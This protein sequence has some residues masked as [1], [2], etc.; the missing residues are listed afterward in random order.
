MGFDPDEFVAA[1]LA[2]RAEPDPVGALA[3]VI[4]AAISDGSSIDQALGTS[5]TP[6]QPDTLLASP[7]LT[8]Q[9]IVFR[10]GAR[11]G[12]HDH[13]M[14]AVVG[15]YAGSEINQLFERG[16]NG[17]VARG[18]SQVERGG[19]SILDTDVIHEVQNPRRE[20]TAGLHVYGGDIAAVAR[21]AWS[22]DHAEVPYS[23]HMAE[24]RVMFE[25]MGELAAEQGKTIS[26]DDRLVALNAIWR[27]CEDQRQC[28]TT[29]QTRAVVSD[30]WHG[31]ILG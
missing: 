31:R 10:G 2:A 12:V 29:A 17:L 3:D 13:R 25:A 1:C 26:D 28:L 21:S 20:W 11:S 8:V 5:V 24:R 22:F 15:V 27:S 23:D 7:A 14:W 9:R 19:V 4:A 6:L 18:A 16:P 30:A